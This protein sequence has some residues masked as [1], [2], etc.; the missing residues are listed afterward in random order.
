MRHVTD[1]IRIYL[2]GVHTASVTY[3]SSLHT[4]KLTHTLKYQTQQHR[5]NGDPGVGPGLG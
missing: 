5:T 4:Y 3:C 1:G 2:I